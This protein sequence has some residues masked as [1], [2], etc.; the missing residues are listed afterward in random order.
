MAALVQLLT[1]DCCLLTF[2]GKSYAFSREGDHW[3]FLCV[4]SGET[5]RATADACTCQDFKF[6]HREC[7][8]LKVL[9]SFVLC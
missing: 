5:Y 2:G 8:H 1:A 4:D 9:R 7:K 3:K 6:R